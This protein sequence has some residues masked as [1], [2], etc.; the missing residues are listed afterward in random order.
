[1]K[2]WQNCHQLK[3]NHGTLWSSEDDIVTGYEVIISALP[4]FYSKRVKKWGNF[5]RCREKFITLHG[6]ILLTHAYEARKYTEILCTPKSP[7]VYDTAKGTATRKPAKAVQLE[8]N[9]REDTLQQKGG[10]KRGR[11]S[12]FHG[13][14]RLKRKPSVRASNSFY[15]RPKMRRLPFPLFRTAYLRE[16]VQLFISNM[17]CDIKNNNWKLKNKNY[18]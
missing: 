7:F 17:I 10:N 6:N 16:K 13:L 5:C 4:Y 8:G 9:N 3:G 14:E 12:N 15:R 11:V 2:R 1:M 18:E